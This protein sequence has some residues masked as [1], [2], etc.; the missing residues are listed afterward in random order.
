MVKT[1]FVRQTAPVQG[2][3]KAFFPSNL[4]KNQTCNICKYDHAEERETSKCEAYECNERHQKSLLLTHHIHKA[5]LTPQNP[6]D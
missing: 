6:D 5:G 1:R 4:G 2:F 3:Q